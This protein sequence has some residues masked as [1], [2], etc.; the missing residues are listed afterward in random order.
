MSTRMTTTAAPTAMAI[1]TPRDRPVV[2]ETSSTALLASSARLR[3]ACCRVGCESAARSAESSAAAACGGAV[4]AARVATRST[5]SRSSAGAAR[6]I[7]V[8]GRGGGLG[9]GAPGGGGRRYRA[10]G[11]VLVPGRSSRCRAAGHGSEPCSS[12]RMTR[13]RRGSSGVPHCW[14]ATAGMAVS[15]N[16]MAPPRHPRVDRDS[17]Q[18]RPVREFFHIPLFRPPR[19]RR[20]AFAQTVF[21]CSQWCHPTRLDVHLTALCTRVLSYG[22]NSQRPR[23]YRRGAFLGSRFAAA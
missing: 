16:R 6:T 19:C 9:G 10:G 14:T 18:R 1:M 8:V 7:F 23:C 3:V 12:A 17:E 2:S 15:A 20:L 21:G 5:A 4:G 22:D 11:R 13:A